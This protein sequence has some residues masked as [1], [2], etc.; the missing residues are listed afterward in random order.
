M[1]VRGECETI[2]LVVSGEAD[3]FCRLLADVD[4]V[5]RITDRHDFNTHQHL[6]R[7]T[8]TY[9]SLEHRFA[10]R[11]CNVRVCIPFCVRDKNNHRRWIKITPT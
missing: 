8:D 4:Y 5:H 9:N 2:G 7:I 11:L 6:H 3:M 10:F 1:L